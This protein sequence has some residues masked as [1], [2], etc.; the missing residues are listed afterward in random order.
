MNIYRIDIYSVDIY[1]VDIYK[2]DT[3]KIDTHKVDIYIEWNIHKVE[4]IECRVRYTWNEI[5]IK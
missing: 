2:I 5:N 3:Y 1:R 4:L